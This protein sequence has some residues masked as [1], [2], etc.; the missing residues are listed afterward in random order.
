MSSLSSKIIALAQAA[1]QKRGLEVRR[2]AKEQAAPEAAIDVLAL[3]VAE[4]RA[5]QGDIFFVQ[6]GAHDGLSFDP[7]RPFVE[8]FHWRGLLVEPQPRVFAR[9]VE[10]YQAEP[11]LLFE[12]AAV[13]R[14]DGAAT[15]CTFAPAPNLP[16][17]ASM[18][19]SFRRE[20]LE[21]NGHGY[22]GPIQSQQVPVLKLETLLRKHSI[23]RIDILQLDTEGFDYEILKM[24][25]FSRVKPALIHFENNFLS[26]DEFAQCSRTLAAQNY[27][28]LTMGIDTIAFQQ[29][30]R[31]FDKRADM[32][33]LDAG[34]RRL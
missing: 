10:N 30:A 11:Q 26:T 34:S 31:E 28:L 8:R 4:L 18:L 14:E 9:L 19:A 33:A 27:R 21:A 25:D 15:L 24:L 32:S 29:D 12:N 5:R 17:H 7:M 13:A 3:C 1:L 2:L 6:I 20:L 16:E 23:E 22:S